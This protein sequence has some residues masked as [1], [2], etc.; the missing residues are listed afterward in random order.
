MSDTKIIIHTFFIGL[1]SIML[2][3]LMLSKGMGMPFWQADVNL[4]YGVFLAL[5]FAFFMVLSVYLVPITKGRIR[6]LAGFGI[7]YSLLILLACY[8]ANMAYMWWRGY[9]INTGNPFEVFWLLDFATWQRKLQLICL[10]VALLLVVVAPTVIVAI[11]LYTARNQ[12]GAHFQTWSEMRRNGLFDNKPTDVFYGIKNGQWVSHPTVALTVIAASQSGKSSAII[13]PNAKKRMGIGSDIFNDNRGELYPILKP[14]YEEAG[15]K[16]YRWSPFKPEGSASIN[17]LLFI[18]F[19]A[20]HLIDDLDV[21]VDMIVPINHSDNSTNDFF[22]TVSCD[23]IRALI[24]YQY[25]KVGKDKNKLTMQSIIELG[26]TNKLEKLLKNILIEADDLPDFIGIALKLF[27]RKVV[28][29]QDPKTKS[30]VMLSAQVNLTKLYS[31][32]ILKTLSGDDI[33]IDQIRHEKMAIFV[34]IPKGKKDKMKNYLAL[35]YQ[36]LITKVTEEGDYIADKH[37]RITCYLD[38][39]GNMA[40]IPALPEAS[41]ELG[42]FGLTFI[43]ILQNMGQAKEVYGNNIA[44]TIFG[45]GSMMLGSTNSMPDVEYFSKTMG[46]YEKKITTGKGENKQVT[47]KDVDLMTPDAIR[48]MSKKYWLTLLEG[49]SPLKLKKG[50]YFLDKELKSPT[51][52]ETKKAKFKSWLDACILYI[53]YKLNLRL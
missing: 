24:I 53:K 9:P 37:Q 49:Q 17:P 48:T 41:T 25:S 5:P 30:N 32:K 28:E 39:F 4:Y 6:R 12:K 51:V 1:L 13:I 31:P 2:A 3:A 33:D 14:R 47:T 43:F 7:I 38:E 18:R 35:F 10:G 27:V 20:D 46:K 11:M 52:S 40:K 42:A 19:E 26:T 15:Y 16:V 23:L 22:R 36:M 44:Q 45:A 29:A 34:E 21:I 8:L 50:F